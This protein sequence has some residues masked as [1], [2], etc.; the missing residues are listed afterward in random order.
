[1]KKCQN[2][3]IIYKSDFNFIKIKKKKKKNLI[4]SVLVFS[5]FFN[6]A[7]EWM[8]QTFCRLSDPSILS[9]IHLWIFQVIC[10]ILFPDRKSLK[11]KLLEMVQVTVPN[12]FLWNLKI[13]LKAQKTCIFYIIWKISQNRAITASFFRFHQN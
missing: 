7:L 4:N 2:L 9:C 5:F 1:M 11:Q 12:F 8:N 3:Y 13:K 6:L 10:P